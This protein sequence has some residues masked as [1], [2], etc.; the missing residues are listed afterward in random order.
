[1]PCMCGDS[2]CWSCSTAQGTRSYPEPSDTLGGL[3]AAGWRHLI[4]RRP[5]LALARRARRGERMTRQD[6]D[7]VLD[8][9]RIAWRGADALDAEL[10]T[11]PWWH[12][13]TLAPLVS[14]LATSI[15]RDAIA[16]LGVLSASEQS[17]MM[18]LEAELGGWIARGGGRS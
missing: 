17:D 12:Q 16:V 4:A 7:A 15:T 6:L 13:A 10:R 3:D 2:E 1:M 14:W 8:A 9:G 18:E 5:T 11:I